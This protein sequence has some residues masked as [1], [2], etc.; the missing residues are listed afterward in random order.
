MLSQA[1]ISKGAIALPRPSATA[2]PYDRS[3][4]GR[5]KQHLVGIYRSSVA[6]LS[7]VVLATSW[8][9][10]AEK[11]PITVKKDPRH[12]FA[13]PTLSLGHVLILAVTSEVRWEIT[14]GESHV[15]YA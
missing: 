5:S 10:T 8:S 13:L 2:P 14:R 3:L 1:A 4:F 6:R 7:A 9:L 15:D 12:A 11:K